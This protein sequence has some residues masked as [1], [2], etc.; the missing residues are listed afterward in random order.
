MALGVHNDDGMVDAPKQNHAWSHD[1]EIGQM[2]QIRKTSTEMG[3]ITV[4]TSS[5][6][7]DEKKA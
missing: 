5:S 2:R 4:L 6:G 3:A 1:M 7:V